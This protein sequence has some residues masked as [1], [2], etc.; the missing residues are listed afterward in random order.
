MMERT[1]FEQ[2]KPREVARLLALVETERRYWQE[3][4]AAL[5]AAVVVLASDRTVV[6]F[7]RAFRRIVKLRHEDLRYKTIEQIFPSDELIEHIRT[8]HLRGDTETLFLNMGGRY[9]R[10]AIVPIRN[11]E[12]EMEPETLLMVEDLSG[13]ETRRPAAAPSAGP[14]FSALPAVLWQADPSTLAFTH[15]AGAAEELLGYP[16][17][18]SSARSCRRA[19]LVPE[20]HR[21]RR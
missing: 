2:W 14:D 1:S 11:W 19:C 16:V 12:E 17:S 13:P 6:S 3:M 20:H 15:A 8:A 18:H 21:D 9:F 4:M 5:P 10:V 7:N